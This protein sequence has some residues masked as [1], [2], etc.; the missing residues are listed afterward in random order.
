MKIFIASISTETNSF[1]P[2]PTGRLSFEE[3]V[4]AHGDATK[5]P[6]EYWSAPL[7][8]WRRRAEERGWEVVESLTAHAQP[9]GPTVREV[10]EEFRDEILADLKAAGPVDVI[11]LSLHGAMIADGYDDCEGDLI[12]AL[13]RGG[14]TEDGHRRAARSALPPDARRC[15][16]TADLLVAYKEYP[17]VDIPE[18]AEDLFDL[19]AD[20]AEGRTK[21][22]MREFDCR[23]ICAMHTPYEP[24][25]ELRRHG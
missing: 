19:A 6:V 7:H 13:P 5:G 23:M 11:L 20:A 14:G 2:L 9:A 17:H 22:V 10:Y 21:P 15:S 25:R 16:T 8:I 12:A 3:G 24:M 18:R 1:S 4:V